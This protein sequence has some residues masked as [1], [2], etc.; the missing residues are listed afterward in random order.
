[1]FVPTQTTMTSFTQALFAVATG[2]PMAAEAIIP[3]PTDAGDWLCCFWKEMADRM[4]D[5]GGDVSV[6]TTHSVEAT[7][8]PFVPTYHGLKA[9]VEEIFRHAVFKATLGNATDII[10]HITLSYLPTAPPTT[11]SASPALRAAEP[12][13]LAEGPLMFSILWTFVIVPEWR[14]KAI[15]QSLF[16]LL[17]VM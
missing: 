2:A 5:E 7:R 1:M 12:S 8:P 6:S 11:T 3:T 17:P 4:R 14:S 10:D 13:A 9:V 15:E 16:F